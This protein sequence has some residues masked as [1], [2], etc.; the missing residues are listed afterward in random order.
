MT[1]I[2]EYNFPEFNRAA[3]YI[4]KLGHEAIN[5]A[6]F[7]NP[8]LPWRDNMRKAIQKMMKADLVVVLDGWDKSRGAQ[9]E[10]ELAKKLEIPVTNMI[11]K[12][13]VR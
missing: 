7:G 4:R 8:Y 11:E 9:I 5:P 12:A 6:E 2:P 13:G 3:A 10:V 1:G